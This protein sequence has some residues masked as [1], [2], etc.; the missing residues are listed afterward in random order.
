MV[1]RVEEKSREGGIRQEVL[2]CEGMRASAACVCVEG[3]GEKAVMS[4]MLSRLSLL[5]RQKKDA[6]QEVC[7]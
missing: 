7:A 3:I 6:S 2:K 4:F 1:C 5:K